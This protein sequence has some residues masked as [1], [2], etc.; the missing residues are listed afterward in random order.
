MFNQSRKWAGPLLLSM[1]TV[2]FAQAP[3]APGFSPIPPVPQGVWVRS[4]YTLTVAAQL[5]VPARFMAIG[6]DGTLYVSSPRQGVVIA[7]RDLDND[8]FYES[9]STF[10]ADY[11]F[12][13]AMQWHDGFLWFAHAGGI[14]KA[15]DNNGDAVADD[16][17]AVMSKGELPRGGGH[18][19]RS[20]LILNSR[21]YTGIGDAGNA[22]DQVDTERQKIFSYTLTGQDK[23]LFAS[24]LRNT[25]KLVNRPGTQEVWGMDHNSDN[26]GQRFGENA[27]RQPITDVN[28]PGE[29]NRIIQDGFYGHPFLTGNRVPRYEYM[30][31]PDLLDLAAKTIVPMWCSGAHWAPNAMTFY[32]ADHFPQQ[33]KGDAFV[34]FHGS[35]NSAKKV[36]YQV[37]RVLF[38]DGKPYGQ[39]S[40]AKFM[41]ENQ[42][43]LAR[44][45][46]VTT[47][48]DGTLLISDDWGKRIYR[49]SY[50]PER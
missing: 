33:I 28:P 50:T 9:Q 4:G 14:H 18:W 10:I 22:T 1:A 49:L 21:L 6:S 35:W 16:V 37:A 25:E 44:P 36:G 11:D 13:H 43:V 26:F 3:A 38:E 17:I 47:A 24:G 23:Q 19:W 15:R 39:L 40:Y 20:L 46:D 27:Q 29:M 48:P 12:V 31:R 34:A 8:G 7:C 41:T 5:D 45:V 32:N 30:D 42:K 2:C